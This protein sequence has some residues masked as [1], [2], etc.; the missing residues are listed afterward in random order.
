M[1]NK[2]CIRKLLKKH[3]IEHTWHEHPPLYTVQD[4]AQLDMEDFL[5]TSKNL[6]L[7]NEKATT[8]YLVAVHKHK[9]V[10]LK[11]LAHI[12]ECKRLSFSNAEELMQYLQVTPGSVSLFGLLNN[13]QNNVNCFIDSD[14]ITSNKIALHPNNNNATIALS[15]KSLLD[16]LHKHGKAVTIITVPEK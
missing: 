11:K 5:F 15:T 12:L 1:F 2:D 4:S 8:F 14:F 13:E 10:D 9:C 16:I 7:R 3:D 6:F